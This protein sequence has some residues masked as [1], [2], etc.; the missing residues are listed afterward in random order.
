[1]QTT[2]FRERIFDAGCLF[3]GQA[4][5]TFGFRTRQPIIIIGTGRCGTNLLVDI[6][7][8]HPSISGFPGEANELWHPT[9]EPFEEAKIELPPIEIDP[10]YF[11]EISIASWNRG[12]EETIRDI[13]SGFHWLSGSSKIFFT[14]SAMIS[15]FIPKILEIF[16][17]AKIIHLFRYGPSVVESYFK[18]NFGKYSKYTYSELEYKTHCANYW[19]ACI[20]EIENKKD[21]F[22]LQL[23]GQFFEFSY[24]ELCRAPLEILNPLADFLGLAVN[25]FGF[26]LAAIA[27]QNYKAPDYTKNPLGMR[28]LDLM[29]P[30][31]R[32]KGYLP[33]EPTT[34]SMGEKNEK[35]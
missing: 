6:L 2:I 7:R 28:L 1:M 18:K 4:A 19:N 3:A 20:L 22:A 26:N 25:G 32:L 10:A 12:H 33:A 30:G 27:S 24:E 8:S 14:K 5:K 31:M 17:Q 16:P 11:S 29:S 15:F 21:E 13:F 34:W 9:L 35:I 23:K